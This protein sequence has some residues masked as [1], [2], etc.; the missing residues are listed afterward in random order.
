MRCK[1][2][3]FLSYSIHNIVFFFRQLHASRMGAIELCSRLIINVGFQILKRK[4]LT[5]NL[6]NLS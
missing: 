5:L 3:H 2:N 6:I 4:L 1:G